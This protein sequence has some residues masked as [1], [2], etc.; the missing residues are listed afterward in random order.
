MH[1]RTQLNSDGTVS[2]WKWPYRL[3]DNY[4]GPEVI[5]ERKPRHLSEARVEELR[6]SEERREEMDK[7]IRR[8]CFPTAE[9]TFLPYEG[10]DAPTKDIREDSRG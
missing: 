1:I 3:G 2:I 4:T 7:R 6:A 8:S 9:G 10:V 5:Y